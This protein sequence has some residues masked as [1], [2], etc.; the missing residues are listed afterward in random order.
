M[1]A[2]YVAC[3]EC[4]AAGVTARLACECG[5]PFRRADE[6][7]APERLTLYGLL[8]KSGDWWHAVADRIGAG[9]GGAS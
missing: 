4:G 9:H 2:R 6:A 1:K 8:P 5:R 7:P 3:P